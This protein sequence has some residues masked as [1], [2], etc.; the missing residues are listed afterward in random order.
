MFKKIA[1]SLL[2]AAKIM[3][4]ARPVWHLYVSVAFLSL[5]SQLVSLIQPWLMKFFLDDVLVDKK[6]ELFWPVIGGFVVVYFVGQIFSIVSSL[7]STRLSQKQQ[8]SIQLEVYDHLQ[9]LHMGF[10]YKKKVGDLLVRVN[11]DSLSIQSFIL[12]V[13]QTFFVN[14]VNLVVILAI[15][16]SL[17]VEATLLALAIFPLYVLSERFWVKRLKRNAQKLRTKSADMFSFLQE[18]LSGI[19]AIKIFKR[20]PEANKEYRERIEDYNLL[21]YKN[22][23]LADLSG[24]V[25]GFILFLPS[26]AV[27]AYGGYKVLLGALTIGSLI[28]LQQYVYRLFGPVLSFIGLNRTLQLEMVGIDRVFEILHAR[29][30]V[31][32]KPGAR[33]LKN[34]KG[35]IEFKNVKFSYDKKQPVLEDITGMVEAGRHIGI[36]GSSGVGKT[37]LVNLLFRFYDPDGGQILLD[38]VNIKN[39]KIRSLRSKIGFVSQ[40]SIIFH[41]SIK[42]NVAFGKPGAN[43][44]EIIAAAR[45]AGI[46][47]AVVRLPKKYETVLGERGETLSAGQRQRIAVARVVLENPDI[48][49]LDEPTSALDSETEKHVT[50]AIETLTKG[51]TTI[52]IAHR[53]KTLK[54][55]D[56]I[57]VLD[58]GTIVEKGNF[59]ELVARKELFF[60]YYLNELI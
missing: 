56:E 29:S 55:A 13:I 4:F 8:M 35:K 21:N 32:D 18:S 39:I 46:H 10:F 17:N 31:K 30:E 50:E 14:V 53:L 24:L 25:N 37:T 20:E 59:E 52:V 28:A 3:S 22:T 60:R 6:I 47:D 26:L 36:V 33:E 9:K 23:F 16:F 38:G 48:I 54:N 11:S 5:L 49:V 42:D 34:V 15:S 1:S 58:H 7:S 45:V 44:E 57:W 19:K 2:K 43:K 27:L 40:E 41:K 51:K 12:T